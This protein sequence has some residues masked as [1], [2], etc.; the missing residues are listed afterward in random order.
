MTT[1]IVY[2]AGPFTGATPWDVACNVRDAET[3]G[4]EVARAGGMPLIPHANTSL[5]SG[6]LTEAFWYQGTLE[7]M[8]RCDG[9]FV[10]ERIR[11]DGQP[12]PGVAAEIAEARRIGMPLLDV[13]DIATDDPGAALE[14]LWQ[15]IRHVVKPRPPV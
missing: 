9:I 13:T 8:R 4:L 6:Q 5:F 3:W 1:P 11:I 15:W 7:L 12:S 2:V 14:E 10:F